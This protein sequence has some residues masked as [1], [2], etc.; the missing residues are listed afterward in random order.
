MKFTITIEDNSDGTVKVEA[1]PTFETIMKMRVSGESITP[2]CDYMTAAILRIH[3]LGKSAPKDESRKL[4]FP[5][6]KNIFK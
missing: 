6:V 2:A 5:K 4:V 1:N 3:Q